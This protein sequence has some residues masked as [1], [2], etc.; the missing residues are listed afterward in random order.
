[1]PLINT[2]TALQRTYWSRHRYL[3][4]ICDAWLPRFRF[5]TLSYIEE[6]Q[7]AL[8]ADFLRL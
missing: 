6:E 7:A 4:N 5:H 2:I 8:A 3:C 1:V